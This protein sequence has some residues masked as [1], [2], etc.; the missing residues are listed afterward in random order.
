MY[1]SKKGEG[2]TKQ[3]SGGFKKLREGGTKAYREP[4]T[5]PRHPRANC[6]IALEQESEEERKEGGEEG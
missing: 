6:C 4:R 5:S 3:E 1:Q 2:Q